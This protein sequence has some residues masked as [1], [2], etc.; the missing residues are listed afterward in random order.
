MYTV[1]YSGRVKELHELKLGVL[2]ATAT[3]CTASVASTPYGVATRGNL[4]YVA[5][6]VATTCQGLKPLRREEI[7]W[8]VAT[9]VATTCQGIRIADVLTPTT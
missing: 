9:V 8:N 2:I 6:Y 1:F 3:R 5:T 7:C 4:F